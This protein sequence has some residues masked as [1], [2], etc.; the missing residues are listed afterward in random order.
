MKQLKILGLA[1]VAA[2]ALSAVAATVASATAA[3]G[4]SG[5]E[6]T[7]STELVAVVLAS[8]ASMFL[9]RRRSALRLAFTVHSSQ[10]LSEPDHDPKQ[11][12]SPKNTHMKLHLA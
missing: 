8:V 1:A 4:G 7:A 9:H 11:E 12:K 2:L 6:E 5:F 10:P 3:V